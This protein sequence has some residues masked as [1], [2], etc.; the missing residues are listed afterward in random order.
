MM[1]RTALPLIVA[2]LALGFAGCA[3]TGPSYEEMIEQ[4]PALKAGDGRIFFYVTEYPVK[5]ALVKINGKK[6]GLLSAKSFFYVDRIAGEYEVAVFRGRAGLVRSDK[7]ALTLSAESIR[8]IEIL[9]VDPRLRM[10][11][12]EPR[13]A[14]KTLRE[15][16][17]MD[18][19]AQDKQEN[20]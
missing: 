6:A 11:L 5:N 12:T 18:P 1:K 14:V 9:G 8:Y 20:P 2:A 15:C 19:A 4:F 13:D 7:M 10:L 3:S 17:Y 16:R